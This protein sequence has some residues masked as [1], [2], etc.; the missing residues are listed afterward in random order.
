MTIDLEEQ[1]SAG[2]RERAGGLAL[3]GDVLGR[4]T[5]R[6]HRRVVTVRAAYAVGVAGL[7]GVLAAGLTLGAAPQTQNANNAPV[8]QQQAP[9]LRL[10]AAAAASDEISYRIRI[11]SG[12]KGAAPGQVSEGAF[13]PRTHTGYLRTD[14]D[15]GVLTEL[16]IDGTRYV[17]T[18]P[19]PG[20]HITGTHEAYSRYGQYAGKYERFDGQGVA[21]SVT[22]DP[23]SLFKALRAAGATTSENPDGRLHFRIEQGP[24]DEHT[25]V[26]GDVTLGPDGRIARVAMTGTWEST[27]KGRL[28]QGEFFTTL[29]LSDYGLA[30]TVARPADVVP[31]N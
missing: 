31:A 23:A 5:R 3:S 22:A 4:A 16:L 2:M 25:T 1:L 17:G 18:E 21:Y 27:R 9:A 13:D 10:A 24:A 7:A 8:V 29:E 20:V 30:V 28:D 26:D 6:H 14:N 19:R 11:S 12:A 15:A